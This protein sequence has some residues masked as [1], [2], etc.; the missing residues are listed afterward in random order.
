MAA[1]PDVLAALQATHDLE[2]TASEKWHKQEHQ[3]KN[4]GAKYPKLGKWF[5]RRHKEAYERQH[6][7]RKRIM[8]LGGT[9]DTNLGDTSYSDDV[10]T[11]FDQACDLLDRLSDSYRGI[12]QAAKDAKDTET[13]EKFHYYLK[14]LQDIYLKGQAK[15]MQLADLGLPLFL[16][17]H[18]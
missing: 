12:L 4:A 16:L 17:K 13:R 6:D 7:L 8:K 14:D 3:F 18:S 10:A 15:Q 9:V 1:D 2:A 11:A 5:D